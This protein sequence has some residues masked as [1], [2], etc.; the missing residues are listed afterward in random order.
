MGLVIEDGNGF[1]ALLLEKLEQRPE[2]A[3]VA[4][5]DECF[6]ICYY[7]DYCKNLSDEEIAAPNSFRQSDRRRLY[8]AF[9][10]YIQRYLR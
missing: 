5:T 8:Q 10:N 3:E 2:A 7:L 6:D 1:D 4:L 9:C